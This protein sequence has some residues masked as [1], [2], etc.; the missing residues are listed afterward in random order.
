MDYLERLDKALEALEKEADRM[1]GLAKLSSTLGE[2]ADELS[3]EKRQIKDAAQDLKI[4]TDT[5][6]K[7]SKEILRKNTEAEELSEK[8]HR[9][10]T[11]KLT[12]YNGPIGLDNKS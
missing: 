3:A 1:T 2:V 5:I 4:A 6:D 9:E 11:E 10:L 8:Q 12:S 7:N